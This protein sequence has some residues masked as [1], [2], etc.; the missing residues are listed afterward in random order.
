MNIHEYKRIES[1]KYKSINLN[2]Y[3]QMNL[4]ESKWMKIKGWIFKNE[5]LYRICKGEERRRVQD[6]YKLC[7]EK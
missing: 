6:E 2:H 3:K 5:Y 1:N 4:N 7:S